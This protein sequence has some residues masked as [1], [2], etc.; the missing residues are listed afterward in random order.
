M[1][2]KKDLFCRLAEKLNF[3]LYECAVVHPLRDKMET[4]PGR[5]HENVRR[6]I[7]RYGGNIVH[8]W[9][10]AYSGCF[11]AHSLWELNGMLYEVTPIGSVCHTSPPFIRHSELPDVRWSE[12]REQSSVFRRFTE[13]ELAAAISSYSTQIYE[14][15]GKNDWCFHHEFSSASMPVERQ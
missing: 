7:Q 13:D 14:L 2:D 11:A 1:S 10:L 12:E 9:L 15:T 5:C 8:G 3:G 4:E 6:V